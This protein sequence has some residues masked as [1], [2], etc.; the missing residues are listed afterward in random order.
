[1]TER[2]ESAL[3]NFLLRRKEARELLRARSHHPWEPRYA[4]DG[5]CGYVTRDDGYSDPDYCNKPK[6]WHLPRQQEGRRP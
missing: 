1:M 5:R 6:D 4:D 2:I 3:F